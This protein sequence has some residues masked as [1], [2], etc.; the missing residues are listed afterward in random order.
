MILDTLNNASHYYASLPGLD[1]AVAALHG[2][3]AD[4]Y[5]TGRTEVDGDHL[6]L[7]ANAYA[8]KEQNE[9]CLMEAHRRYADIMYMVE[10]EETILVKPTEQLTKIEQ[11]YDPAGDALLAQVDGDCTAVCLKAG[12]F[13][14]LLPQDAHCPAL[15]RNAAQVKKVICKLELTGSG[16]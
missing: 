2:F 11:E 9:D 12:Q 4:D 1:Q 15:R 10:G 8:P 5:I 16:R 3:N 6:F 13:L 14:V 7:L